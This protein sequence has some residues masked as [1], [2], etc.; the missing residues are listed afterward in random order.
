MARR[1]VHNKDELK[2]LILT[3]AQAIIRQE[4]VRGL[5]ARKIAAQIGYTVGTLY[6]F[7]E[8]I[9]DIILH[10]NGLTLDALASS[11]QSIRAG[12][13]G[14]IVELGYGY[15]H[16]AQEYYPLWCLLFEHTIPQA[17]YPDWYQAKIDALFCLVEEAISPMVPQEEIGQT[18]KI[19]FAGLQGIAQLSLS[20]RLDIIGEVS[21]RNLVK[22]FITRYMRP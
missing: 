21:G 12:H 20:G 15:M 3:A 22:A 1:N 18:A 13:S 10:V 5:T 6:S 14:D 8:G 17:Q 7:F 2:A 11:L 19:L 16:F 4:G 9:D